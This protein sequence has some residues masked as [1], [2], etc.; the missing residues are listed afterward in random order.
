MKYK[1]TLFPVPGG[2]WIFEVST[3]KSILL[4]ASKMQLPRSR[5]ICRSRAVDFIE[6]QKG[7]NPKDEIKE[8]V[9]DY[10]L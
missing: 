9:S 4:H 8:E 6:S 2:G 10:S 1:I 7:F 5:E 3:K